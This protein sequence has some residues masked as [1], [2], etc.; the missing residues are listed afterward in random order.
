MALE[1]LKVLCLCAAAVLPAASG[2][3]CMT[4]DSKARVTEERDLTL[5][6]ETPPQIGLSFGAAI[7][8]QTLAVGR[9]FSIPWFDPLTLSQSAMQVEVTGVELLP[10]GEEAY[11]L[12][13]NLGGIQTRRLVTPAG[14]VLREEGT[15]GL[16]MVRTTR[17]QAQSL[18]DA[19]EPVDF[20]AMA[21]IEPHTPIQDPTHRVQLTLRISGV[22]PRRIPDSPP[23]QRRSGDQV[24][25]RMPLLAELPA[26]TLP[27]ETLPAEDPPSASGGEPRTSPDPHTGAIQAAL[28]PEPFLPAA[29]PEIQSTAAEIVAGADNL[30]DKALLLADW[31]FTEVAKR[32][33]VGVPNGL[34][35][36]R[37]K[38][39][40]CNEHT[41]LYVSLARAAG[42]PARIAAGLVYSDRV[43]QVGAFYYHAWPEVYLGASAGWVPI[44]P[45]FGEFPADATHLKLV[46]GNLDRQVE[47]IAVMGRLQLEPVS[48]HTQPPP[49]E[50]RGEPVPKDA[51]V[52]PSE[53]R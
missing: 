32:P 11:W 50:E 41:A 21:A 24:T 2:G 5:P 43:S 7:A 3:C 1:S 44:D 15:W 28:R 29:H 36:L 22:D 8:R 33:V 14:D 39:G 30:R 6:M 26:E 25:L 51:V 40:D 17:E 13:T 42:V 37:N 16:S 48:P 18:L 53:G 4:F 27:A 38:V 9:R 23:I 52:E 47:I 46:E 19:G 20:I 10:D 12:Q 35:V 49:A 34:E 45:T 31:V